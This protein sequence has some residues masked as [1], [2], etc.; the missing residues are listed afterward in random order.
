M[1]YSTSRNIHA[2]KFSLRLYF[3]VVHWVPSLLYPLSRNIFPV[4]RNQFRNVT[5]IPIIKCSPLYVYRDFP[6]A[7]SQQ[8]IETAAIPMSR[9][10]CLFYRYLDISRLLSKQNDFK[11]SVIPSKL[12]N[13]VKKFEITNDPIELLL[14]GD[15]SGERSHG[16]CFVCLLTRRL[17][18]LFARVQMLLCMVKT[19]QEN[20]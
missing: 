3:A 15:N 18:I 5:K 10:I 19:E 2:V 1:V 13:K 11:T 12:N 14:E 6:S 4:Y 8:F 17:W 16:F 7:T 9:V 20:I